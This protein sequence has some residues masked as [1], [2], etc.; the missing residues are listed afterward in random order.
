MK[1]SVRSTYGADEISFST[2]LH[3]TAIANRGIFRFEIDHVWSSTFAPKHI[4]LIELIPK[5][6]I[7]SLH[8]IRGV[9][10][11]QMK[12]NGIS[13]RRSEMTIE[14][15]WNLSLNVMRLH[16]AGIVRNHS[17]SSFTLKSIPHY[18][19]MISKWCCNQFLFV[20]LRKREI[21]FHQQKVWMSFAA[22]TFEEKQ[23]E[24]IENGKDHLHTHTQTRIHNVSAEMQWYFS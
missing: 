15:E 7:I 12:F 21:R 2:R 16:N 13:S 9:G 6:V 22:R 18:Q 5:C 1:F 8:R 17:S 10:S 4:W 3:H 11:Y 24:L 20:R 14:I 19:T 23:L